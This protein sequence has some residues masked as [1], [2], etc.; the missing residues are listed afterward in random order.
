M[1]DGLPAA[2]CLLYPTTEAGVD[3]LTRDLRCALRSLVRFK[4][5]SVVAIACMAL[6][7]GVCA[8]LF[9]AVNPWLFRPL[10]FPQPNRLVGLRQTQPGA[11]GGF[12]LLSGPDYLDVQRRSARSFERLG[13]CQRTELN[14][15]TADAPVRVQAALVTA[16]LFPT[17]RI[18]PIR[19]RNFSAEED[20]PGGARSVL[21][22][23]SLWQ[24]RFGGSADAVGGTLRLDGVEHTIIGVMPPRFA[25]PHYAELWVPLRLE[26]DEAKRGVR[27]VNTVAR[28][29]DG[30]TIEQ[31]R[32]E[33]GTIAA[34]LQREHPDT[35]RDSRIELRTLLGW[36][37]PPGVAIGLRLLLAA[38]L[39]IQ[40]IACSNV[41]NL[42]LAKAVAQRREVAIRLALGAGRARLLRQFLL[43]ALVIAAAGSVL[44]VLAGQWG[45]QWLLSGSSGAV[46]QPYWVND[47][48]DFTGLAVV[49]II[50]VGSALAVA[51]IPALQADGSRVF[52]D[53]KEGSRT[54]TGARQGRIGRLLVVS[55]LG[56][57]LVLLIGAALMVQ[58]FRARQD[59]DPGLELRPAL[60]TR[61]VLSGETDADGLK[62]AELLQELARR[63]RALPGVEQAGFASSLPFS[64][65]QAGG[66]AS[67]RF[68]VDGHPVEPEKLP[69]AV[70]AS[71]STGYFEATGIRLRLGRF[72]DTAEEEEGRPVVVVSEDLA[73]SWGGADPIG[74]RLRVQ[75]GPWLRVVGVVQQ[76]RESG[77]MVLAGDKPPSQIYIP[78]RLDPSSAVSLVVRTS[79]EPEALSGALRATLRALDP[80]LPL[81]QV[82][83]LAESRRR[84]N[85][86]AE[87][88]GS[89]MTKVAMLAL[90]L[91]ALG[92]YGV[93][94]HMVSQRTHEIGLRM[95]IGASRRDVVGLVVRQGLRLALQSA[96][97]GLL[98]ALAFSR[99]L[100]SLLFGVSATDPLIF[101]GCAAVLTL[102]ALA[103]SSAPALRAA[104]LDPLVAL[105]NE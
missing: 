87:R 42:L 1:T 16:S 67:R 52:A 66:W 96:V 78:Y 43:E 70:Y 18:Q 19:G 41:A 93:V 6:G 84:A 59:M 39:F 48:L 105:R 47:D 25:Y 82:Y 15:S 10:P 104:R 55:E 58:S 60:T 38:G 92:V 91:A 61:L 5:L 103:A 86:V 28:L 33:L 63:V 100:S 80:G 73:R 56:L 26:Q 69:R 77:D 99:A 90:L 89:M 53:I 17:L 72:F 35:H 71:A 62:R 32:A 50:A 2:R 23:H 101:G 14:L 8:T 88:W 34:A 83:S 54:V 31:A 64:D 40:L 81:G 36:L 11:G 57:A 76:T 22:G 65:P 9:A 68:E 85:W 7:I 44:G 49:A 95:A 4:G 102:A 20:R 98:A 74:Q 30:V 13:G 29:R 45:M 12:S 37:T 46:R 79:A 21:I 75:G 24:S 27:N 94:S 3:S 97:A 51:A